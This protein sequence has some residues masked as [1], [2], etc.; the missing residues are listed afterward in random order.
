MIVTTEAI[1]LR[2][3]K[4]GETSKIAT[5][6]TMDYGKLNVIAKG[7]REVKSKFGAALEMFAHTSVVLY[8]RDTNEALNLLSKADTID[9]HSGILRSLEKMETATAIV[10]LVLHSMHDE[11]AHANLFAL[12][13]QSLAAIAKT[14]EENGRLHAIQIRF[15]LFFTEMMGFGLDWDAVKALSNEET[16][17]LHQLAESP[18]PNPL[19]EGEGTFSNSFPEGEG[20][21]SEKE[22]LRLYSFF[23]SYFAEHL[24]GVTNRSMKSGRVFSSL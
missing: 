14:A 5:L 23:Q 10:E 7:A 19:P 8:K 21:L 3:R 20:I 17:L 1:V 15:Y 4:Q 22:F 11:D 16:A 12:L 13:N 18:H 2:A 9:S 24:P 6:Y